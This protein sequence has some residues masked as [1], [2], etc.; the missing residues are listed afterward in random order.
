MI[1]ANWRILVNIDSGDGDSAHPR[2]ML[3]HLSETNS[4]TSVGIILPNPFHR[5]GEN[6]DLKRS[7]DGQRSLRLH[8]TSLKSLSILKIS[9]D[10]ILQGKASIPV[11][12]LILPLLG[13]KQIKHACGPQINPFRTSKPAVRNKKTRKYL[14]LTFTSSNKSDQTSLALKRN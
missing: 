12:F 9:R 10:G 11:L 6:D 14:T 3:S 1:S 2:G 13:D 4:Q 5:T 7:R 8:S